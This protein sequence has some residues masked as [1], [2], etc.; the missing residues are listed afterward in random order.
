MKIYLILPILGYEL[1]QKRI[2]DLSRRVSVVRVLDYRGLE[3]EGILSFK[4]EM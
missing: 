4:I 3:I 1:G 2:R